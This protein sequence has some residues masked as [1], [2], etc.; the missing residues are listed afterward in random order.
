MIDE[1]CST[2]RF[3]CLNIDILGDFPQSWIYNSCYM[4]L[5][6]I[7]LSATYTTTHN[8]IYHY[9]FCLVV[10]VHIFTLTRSEFRILVRMIPSFL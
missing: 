5:N 8:N 3:H 2:N 9:F 7:H 10:Y 4:S 1:V 6:I